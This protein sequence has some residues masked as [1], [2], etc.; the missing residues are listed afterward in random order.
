MTR[1]D[2]VVLRALASRILLAIGVFFGMIALV[3]S[4]DTWRFNYLSSVGG[5]P[6]A[7]LGIAMAAATWLLKGLSVVVLVGAVVGVMDLQARREL[8][9]IKASGASMWRIL[10]APTIALLLLGFGVTLLVE[11]YVI[12]ANRSIQAT[13]PGDS[14]LSSTD[15]LWLEQYANGE[16]YVLQA[17]HVVDQG[18]E[19]Q[20]VAIY[21][22]DGLK[23]GRILAPSARLTDGAW[24]MEKATRY[25]AGLPP[26]PLSNYAI[27]TTTTPADLRVKLTNTDDMTFYELAASVSSNLTDPVLR[28]AVT[29]RF[30][31]LLALPA[32]LVGALFIAFAFTAGYR[33]SNGYGV[34]IAYAILTGFV[35]FVITEMADRAGSAGVLEPTFAACGPAFVAIVIGLTVLLYR[36]DGWA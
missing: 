23:E 21:L 35:V 10:R 1:F 30:F 8:I 22:T 3:E 25:R 13:L 5:V 34:P 2:W 16:R 17:E 19:L 26:E 36:E 27:P 15:G 20:Q 28:D 24:V 18:R 33:R 31:R 7:L 29:T 6:L 32:L 9:A 4:I 12:T 14:S 11:D